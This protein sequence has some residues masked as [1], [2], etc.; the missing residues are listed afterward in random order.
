MKLPTQFILQHKEHEPLT[1]G[2]CPQSKI[3]EYT[4]KDAERANHPIPAS[5]IVY[6]SVESSPHYDNSP[7]DLYIDER[8]LIE[9]PAPHQ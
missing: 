1:E 4:A 3:D 8:D 9:L 5:S 6:D 7:N 2:K